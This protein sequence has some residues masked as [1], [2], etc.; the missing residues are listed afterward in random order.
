MSKLVE[1]MIIK[2]LGI[3]SLGS[4]LHPTSEGLW[5]AYSRWPDRQTRDAFWP[6]ENIS[7]NELPAEIRHAIMTLKDC[8]DEKRK[9]PEICMEVIDDLFPWKKDDYLFSP[10]SL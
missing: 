6:G 7:F 9:I 3:K 1:K 2:Q 10:S 5:V 4:C 8:M